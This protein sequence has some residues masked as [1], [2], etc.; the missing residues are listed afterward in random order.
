MSQEKNKYWGG[1]WKAVEKARPFPVLG[2]VGGAEVKIATLI[3]PKDSQ[4]RM[5]SRREE[6]L[7]TQGR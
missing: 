5:G 2:I 1:L 4:I 3:S 6:N 7:L